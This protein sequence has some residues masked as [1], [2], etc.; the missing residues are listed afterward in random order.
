MLRD[1]QMAYAGACVYCHSAFIGMPHGLHDLTL[2]IVNP[3]V[4][5]YYATN[6]RWCC[7]TC[8]RAKQQMSPEAWGGR[9]AFWDAYRRHTKRPVQPSF[10]D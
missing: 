5:P 3:T 6:V 10:W 2:D 1:V 4:Q 8:N 9:C 7:Q